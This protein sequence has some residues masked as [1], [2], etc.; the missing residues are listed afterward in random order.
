M[1]VYRAAIMK[2]NNALTLSSYKSM[3]ILEFCNMEN[4]FLYIYTLLYISNENFFVFLEQE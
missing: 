3:K 1:Y 2:E 4:I